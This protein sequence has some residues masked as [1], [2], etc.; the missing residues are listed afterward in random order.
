MIVSKIERSEAIPRLEDITRA[1]D[2]IMV[3]RGDLGVEVGYAKLTGL[4]KRILH[5]ARMLSLIHI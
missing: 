3:A 2:A 4:Q 1:S 5:T